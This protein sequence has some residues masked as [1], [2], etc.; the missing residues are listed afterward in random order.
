MSNPNRVIKI[1]KKNSPRI[2][3]KKINYLKEI[4]EGY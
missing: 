3:E 2:G 1:T 4:L